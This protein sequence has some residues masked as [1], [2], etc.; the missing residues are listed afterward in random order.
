MHHA[1]QCSSL[2]SIPSLCRVCSARS[3]HALCIQQAPND[4]PHSPSILRSPI[5]TAHNKQQLIRSYHPLLYVLVKTR[6]REVRQ[7]VVGHV[8]DGG[9]S[10]EKRA[11]NR[12]V[13]CV[14]VD[15]TMHQRDSDV[16]TE[17]ACGGTQ[18]EAYIRINSMILL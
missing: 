7:S 17:T 6:Q 2:Y 18:D 12:A 13:L 9:R 4:G 1:V 15:D 3:S 5:R 8:R 16:R 10:G 11:D 14:A